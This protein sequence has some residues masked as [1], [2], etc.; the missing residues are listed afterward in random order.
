MSQ[1]FAIT[2]RDSSPQE[3]LGTRAGIVAAL[4]ELNTASERPDEDILWGPGIKVE[5]PPGQDPI[6]QML[7]TVIEEEIAGLAIMRI[8]RI[9]QWRIVDLETGVEMEPE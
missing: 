9:C 5:M 6:T 7:L 1:Q 8:G 2:T 3:L 4:A